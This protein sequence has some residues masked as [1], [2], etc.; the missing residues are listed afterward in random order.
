MSQTQTKSQLEKTVQE[1]KF[2]LESQI[3]PSAMVKSSTLEY[4]VNE[5]A[6]K[7]GSASWRNETPWSKRGSPRP[8]SKRGLDKIDRPLGTLT[9][10]PAVDPYT[11]KQR[12]LFRAL[13]NESNWILRANV[14]IQ[15]LVMTRST[16]D[17]MPRAETE[18]KE[19]ELKKWQEKP[20]IYVPYWDKKY[21]PTY[22]KKWIDKLYL[23]LKIPAVLFNA[24][25]IMR[26]QGRCAVG[27]F[28][29]ER[30]AESGKYV[31][32]QAF[33]YIEAEYTRRPVLNFD[34]GEL[35]AV[36]IV[37]I[38]SNGGRLDANRC[39]YMTN[40][41]NLNL[42]SRYYGRSLVEPVQS[43][44]KTLQTIYDSDFP[45]AAE[46][47]WH[48]PN[49]F[50]ITIPARDYDKVDKVQDEFNRKINDNSGKDISVTQAVELLNSGGGSNSGDISGLIA[51]VNEDVDAILGF[52]NIPPFM[53]SKSKEGALG[54]NNKREEI[55]AFL[56]TEIK[57]EQEIMENI[58]EDQIY[59]RILAILFNV[60]PEEVSNPEKCPVKMKHFFDKP[61]IVTSVDLEQYEIAKDQRNEGLIDTE[62]LLDKFG[63]R[64]DLQDDTI[65]GGGASDPTIKTWDV[66]NKAWSKSTLAKG[67]ILA[68]WTPKNLW[69]S[70]GNEWKGATG[71]QGESEV[72]PKGLMPKDWTPR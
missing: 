62:D 16:S 58:V 59:D 31:I 25:L 18:L 37:G 40:S 60:E 45:H 22:I 21:S 29:E 55:D 48:K 17:I 51:I 66:P 68:K 32:P 57:P 72:K 11:P 6:F 53:V 67:S 23:K 2:L 14:I 33:R 71:W 54:G 44:G 20:E 35:A 39:V 38:S 1:Q 46:F 9:V 43:Q 70:K 28:P 19:E 26:E 50:Q 30:N 4:Q 49:I 61:H 69:G 24:Y 8:D 12:A 63:L 56:E 41:D 65:T 34:T 7:V 52:Y 5:K 42:F 36:E 47:T 3:S 64:S 10:F 27:M 13:M 15:K